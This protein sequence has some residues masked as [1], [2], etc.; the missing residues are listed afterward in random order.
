MYHTDLWY[1]EQE[2]TGTSCTTGIDTNTRYYYFKLQGLER[3]QEPSV[4]VLHNDF[5]LQAFCLFFFLFLFFRFLLFPDVTGF[6]VGAVVVVTVAAVTRGDFSAGC[7]RCCTFVS[8]RASFSSTL[9]EV[10]FG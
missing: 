6:S 1:K 3:V 10:R 2:T 8:C 7:S 9:E 4:L 5:S